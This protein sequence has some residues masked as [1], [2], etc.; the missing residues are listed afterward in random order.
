[1]GQGFALIHR[2]KFTWMDE[3]VP[4]PR[5][6]R[7]IESLH[8]PVDHAAHPGDAAAAGMVRKPDIEW[9]AQFDLDG[10]HPSERTGISWK[11]ANP[12]AVGDGPVIGAAD[13]RLHHQQVALRESG[14]ETFE[15]FL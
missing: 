8:Q 12:A 15:H 11:H 10:D 6:F 5:E 9:P 1:M 7:G 3:L 4:E 13:I 14:E 2:V